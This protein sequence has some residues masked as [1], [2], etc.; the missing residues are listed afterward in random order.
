MLGFLLALGEQTGVLVGQFLLLL[1][2]LSLQSML[3][4]LALNECRRDES[5]NA[6]SLGLGLLALLYR[7]WSSNDVLADIV[8]LCQVEKL[9]D[10]VSSLRTES[11]RNSHVGQTSNFS[12]S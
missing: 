1:G 4:T 8:F 9:S 10:S 6:G 7:Q 12:G 2:T 11:S 5:L 3:A